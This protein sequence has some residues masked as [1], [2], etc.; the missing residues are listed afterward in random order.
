MYAIVD[1]YMH[2]LAE[3]VENSTS[4]ELHQMG[5]TRKNVKSLQRLVE[6]MDSGDKKEALNAVIKGH[7]KEMMA[8]MASV[9]LNQQRDDQA[10]M[11]SDWAKLVSPPKEVAKPVV[12]AEEE[13]KPIGSSRVQQAEEGTSY[14]IAPEAMKKSTERKVDDA[15]DEEVSHASRVS[16]AAAVTPRDRLARAESSPNIGIGGV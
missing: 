3:A 10:G 5:L 16:K 1:T 2:K 12:A 14:A 15:P 11:R 7:H 13:H 8:M 4:E 9:M 6:A